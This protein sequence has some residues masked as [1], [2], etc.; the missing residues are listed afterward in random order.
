MRDLRTCGYLAKVHGCMLKEGVKPLG[1]CS[2]EPGAYRWILTPVWAQGMR[3]RPGNACAHASMHRQHL[4]PKH[5][6]QVMRLL[7]H[8]GGVKAKL[9]KWLKTP[10]R[11]LPF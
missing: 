2:A 9:R 4:E 5:W 3:A 10:K 6:A 7:L 11:S 1:V 8:H